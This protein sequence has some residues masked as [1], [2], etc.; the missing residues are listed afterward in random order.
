[1]VLVCY[2]IKDSS[3]SPELPAVFVAVSS[4]VKIGDLLPFYVSI[5][6]TALLLVFTISIMTCSE[7]ILFSLSRSLLPGWAVSDYRGEPR[8]V[9]LMNRCSRS[10]SL[11][12]CILPLLALLNSEP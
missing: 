11:G 9:F 1:M 8:K 7:D 10:L 12:S 6:L 3:M 2:F 5:F 4:P